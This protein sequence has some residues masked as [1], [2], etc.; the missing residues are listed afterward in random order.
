MATIHIAAA[1]ISWGVCEVPGWGH[2]LDPDRVLS[3]MAELGFEA[4]EFGPEGFLPD[5]PTA[6]ADTLAGHSLKAVGGFVPAVLH[7]PGHDPL[8]QIHREL[9]G[10]EATGA[11]TL[12]LAAA[13]GIDGYD[14]ERPVLGDAGWATVIGN[15]DRILTAA[16]DVGVKVAL[17]PHAGT[18]VETQD[19]VDH[20]L[21]GTSLDICFD[22]G[23]MFI[24]G[25]DPVAFARD[26]ADRVSHAHLKDVSLTHARSVRA[27]DRAYYD[28]VVDGMYRPLGQGD[29]DIVEIIRSLL[30]SGF[31]G[32]FVLEQ[33][34]VIATDDSDP[35]RD[36]RASLDYLTRV[37]EAVH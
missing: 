1:P 25:I 29:I 26:H 8:P 15:I 6:K 7:D 12:V 2:Q 18:M 33:D 30:D 5:S 21:D 37:T 34:T 4:T 28:A 23:H 27:G 32:W 13:T 20:I 19:D 11:G 31:D 17:H 16:A 10:Y 35:A 24:G 9:A 22:T 36:V 3:E 14:A